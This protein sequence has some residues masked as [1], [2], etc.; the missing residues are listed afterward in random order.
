[1]S[2]RARGPPRKAP[3]PRT[4][5]PRP[6]G[7]RLMEIKL[8]R[9]LEPETMAEEVS[10]PICETRF[11]TGPVL[12]QIQTDENQGNR[13]CPACIAILGR[14][15]PKKFPTIE[16]YLAACERYPEPVFESEDEII[17]LQ[18]ADDPSWDKRY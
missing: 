13:L 8:Q 9:A 1:M 18:E 4:I 3:R 10:C 6:K 15:N 12:A 16:E 2:T 14:H 11:V 5:S 17:G 7:E